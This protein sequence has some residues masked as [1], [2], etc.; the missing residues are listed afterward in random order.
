VRLCAAAF[1]YFAAMGVGAPVLPGYVLG[2]AG[3][4]KLE[5][6]LAVAAFSLSSL[7][8][9]PFV[10][11]MARRWS[12]ARLVAAGALVVGVAEGLL[13]LAP[14]PEL[15]VL[16]RA[17]AGVGEAVFFV[18]LSSAV[19]DLVSPAHQG[20]AMSYFSAVLSAALL[21]SPV[22]GELVRQRA[23]YAAVW[24]LVFGLCAVAALLTWTLPLAR[25]PAAAAPGL[26]I[27]HRSGLGPGLLLAVNTWGGAA[28]ITFLALYVAQL[29]LGGAAPE[30]AAYGVV[31]LA[32]RVLGA[33]ALDHADPRAAALFAL[34]LQSISMLLFA[35]ARSSLALVAC[36][37]LFGA[38]TAFGY[39]ALMSMA[40]RTAPAAERA[41]VV[42]TMTA[43]FDAGYAAAALTL[44][45]A[46][47][48]AGFSAVFLCAGAV[49]AAGAAVLAR[50]LLTVPIP[51]VAPLERS[52]S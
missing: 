23:G 29:G 18:L 17:L 14:P 45:G 3:G 11:P 4:T 24:I 13:V 34:A 50:L 9:R 31:V 48:L 33:R 6:G 30:F 8:L 47:A 22:L 28:F 43:C 25:Q 2:P 46:F 49:L 37:G 44:A 16:L 10:V 35:F 36:S 15:V 5:L 7:L 20:R 38:G 42:A 19:Y 21:G 27:V 26:R 40:I 41:E 51:A 52:P 12:P 39:P 1:A 32:A